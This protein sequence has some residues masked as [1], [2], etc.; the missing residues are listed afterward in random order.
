LR[1][2]QVGRLNPELGSRWDLARRTEAVLGLLPRLRLKELISHHIPFE[3]APEAYRLVDKSP[4]EAVQVVLI[5]D[6]G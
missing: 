5:H 1:S 4:D 2:S 3:E 6:E